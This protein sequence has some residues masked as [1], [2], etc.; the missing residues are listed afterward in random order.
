[1]VA[2]MIFIAGTGRAEYVEKEPSIV[3]YS[4]GAQI[5]II[6]PINVRIIGIK[7]VCIRIPNFAN[8]V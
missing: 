6:N 3:Y 5:N 1:M 4:I 2:T 8:S 7:E